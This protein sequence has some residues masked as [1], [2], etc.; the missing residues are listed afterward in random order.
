MK[1]DAYVVLVSG[2]GQLGSR[3]LQGLAKCHLP[4]RIF[5]QDSSPE[6]LAR[7]RIRWDEVRGPAP[8]HNVSY[9]ADI[10]ALPREID[11][12]IVS[13][14]ADVRPRVVSEIA[15]HAAVRFWVLEKV[16]AQ[17]QSDIDEIVS[18]VGSNSGAWIN[19]PR[20]V[21]PW[22]WQIK[23]QL[24]LATPITLHVEG[25]A[26]GLACNAIH[27]LDLLAWWSGETLQTVSTE[28]LATDWFASKRSGI[29]EIEGTLEAKFSGGSSASLSADDSAEPVHA[30]VTDGRR[31]WVIS[32]S[33]GSAVCTD[34]LV[35][36]GRLA[37]QSE[38]TAPLIESVLQGNGCELPTLEESAA[39]H[40]VFINGMLQHWRHTGDASA[41]AVPIT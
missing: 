16:L 5:V 19:T 1:T 41:L 31:I 23:A 20:R 30:E 13:T 10:R 35:I 21:M 2:A 12:S 24:S 37:Y 34:G 36:P 29:R 26:W 40:R 28:R 38:L 9:H 14:T 4:L 8:I 25:G 22:H 6:S 7:A 3:Y 27:F 17:S 39:M 32:E 11:V 33:E 18:S 15:G